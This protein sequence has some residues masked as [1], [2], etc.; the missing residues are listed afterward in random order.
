MPIFKPMLAGDALAAKSLR[1]PLMASPKL[2]GIRG[3]ADSSWIRSRSL[4]M[5]PNKH[6]QY[7]F[8]RPELQGFDG[9][10]IC[11]APNDPHT[12][13][14]SNSAVMSQE[15]EPNVQ[16]YAFDIWNLEGVPYKMRNLVLQERID[17]LKPEIKKH[18]VLVEQTVLTNYDE[19][20]DYEERAIN[21]GYEGVMLRSFDGLYKYGRSTPKEGTL[22]KLKRFKDAEAVIIDVLP[23][24]HNLNEAIR[25]EVG[26]LQRSTSQDGLQAM[27]MIG[28][29]VVRDAQD[30]EF[31]VAPGVMDHGMRKALWSIRDSLKSKTIKFKYFPHGE[32]DVPRHPSFL[33]FRELIDI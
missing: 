28:A 33:G 12:Y 13:I 30:R 29:F 16:F 21:A 6:V 15:G 23:A 14:R 4:K 10:L 27:D 3:V 19:L 18:I 25:N 7:L 22:L 9:E 26:A 11:G 20:S 24:M 1:F 2:D 8:G 31:K 5:I 32:K 17:N